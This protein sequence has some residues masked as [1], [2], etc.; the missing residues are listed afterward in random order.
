VDA[1]ATIHLLAMPNRSVLIAQA[2][3]LAR[4]GRAREIRVSRGLSQE[5]IARDTGVHRTA[6]GHWERG[7]AMPTGDRAIR[8]L[9]LMDELAQV[10]A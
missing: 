9:R 1:L 2:V 6:V 3:Q 10:P 7:E 8:W 4:S 5:A